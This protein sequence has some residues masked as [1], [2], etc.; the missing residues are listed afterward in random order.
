ME[1]LKQLDGIIRPEWHVF[2]HELRGALPNSDT[3]I[4]DAA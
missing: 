3:W 1:M 2:R 4:P